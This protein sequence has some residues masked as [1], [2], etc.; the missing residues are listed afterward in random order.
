MAWFTATKE[1]MATKKY[2]VWE[3]EKTQ[4]WP[5]KSGSNSPKNLMLRVPPWPVPTLDLVRRETIWLAKITLMPFHQLR[6]DTHT[7]LLQIYTDL[8]RHESSNSF[9]GIL[10]KPGDI[11]LISSDR[12]RTE[13]NQSRPF[14]RPRLMTSFHRKLWLVLILCIRIQFFVMQYNGNCINMKQ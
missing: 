6:A 4:L 10:L 2:R 7:S 13:C 1:H 14:F 8:K 5:A 3:E 12:R 11:L 9:F